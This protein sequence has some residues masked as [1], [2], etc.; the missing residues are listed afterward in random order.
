MVCCRHGKSLLIILF[1][2]LVLIILSYTACT[3]KAQTGNNGEATQNGA[4]RQ[5]PSM[6]IDPPQKTTDRQPVI[7]KPA[8]A[9]TS[10]KQSFTFD[11][12]GD[13]KILPGKENWLGNRVLAEAVTRINQ[14]NPT[15]VVYLGDGADQGGPVE[16]LAAFRSYLDKLQPS[17]YPVIGNH[18]LN[19][20]ADPNGLAGNGEGN[21][22][23]VFTDKL[24]M[25][26]RSY[27]SFNY[28][29]THFIV[30]DTAWQSGYG[31][32]EAELKPGSQQWE[33]LSQDL[34]NASK[35]SRHIFIFGHKPPVSPFRAGGPDTESNLPDGHGS[36]WGDPGVAAEFMQLVASYHVDAVFSGHIHMYNRLDIQGL[37]YIITAGAGASLYASQESGGFYHYVKCRI[38]G[39]QVSYEVVKLSP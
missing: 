35:Q 33:W 19:K 7:N 2:L 26:G 25:Q 38:D 17:W 37:P 5:S 1:S 24:P 31:P 14:D 11:V 36:S 6:Q 12:L 21:F 18:E 39:E 9:I 8:P 29:N 15:L 32:A 34:E 22:Q 4:V 3:Q 13:S 23:R 28:L 10:N 30:L 27:Y 20:G 16:N